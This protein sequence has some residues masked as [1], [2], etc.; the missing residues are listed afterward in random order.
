MN[1][2]EV[3]SSGLLES[4]VLGTASAEE[5][6]LVN[7][8]CKEH[9]ALIKE[10]EAIED[11]LI[12]F[13]AHVAP[14]INKDLKDKIAAQLTFDAE[15]SPVAKV[16]S[17]KKETDSRLNLYKLGIAASLL[18]FMTS[19]MYNIQL[20]HKLSKMSG[21]LAELNAS[22]SYMADQLNIQQTSLVTMNMELQ[23]LANPK[24]K[25]VALKGMNTLEKKSAMVH[26]N[27][28]SDE[29]YFNA[30]VLPPA[31]EAKQY[32][33]WAIVDGKPV[34]I[35]MIDMNS[36]EN[37]FQKMKSVRGAQAFAVTIEQIGGRPTPTMEAM[38]LLGNV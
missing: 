36:T 17:I 32:Q 15:E 25:T 29:V 31:P 8:L 20:N 2:N 22:K 35:G 30:S 34:D 9:P 33:L 26:M 27:M 12:N 4:Y 24:V 23:I 38:V 5:V 6:A 21:E 3:I 37:V 16:I 7:K 28:E 1:I 11:S 19:L 18:L 10:I 14:S 13:S